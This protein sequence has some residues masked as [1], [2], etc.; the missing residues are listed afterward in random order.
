MYFEGGFQEQVIFNIQVALVVF[1]ARTNQGGPKTTRRNYF[2]YP[3]EL[4]LLKIEGLAFSIC[5]YSL[6]RNALLAKFQYGL[7]KCFDKFF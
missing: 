4:F 2:Q 7:N 1:H 5:Y 3:S 6:I